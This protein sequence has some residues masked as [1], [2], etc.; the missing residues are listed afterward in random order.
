MLLSSMVYIKLNKEILWV[1]CLIKNEQ[2]KQD[3]NSHDNFLFFFQAAHSDIESHGQLIK[4]VVELCDKYSRKT[5][6]QRNHPSNNSS[7][8]KHSIRHQPRVR[9]FI[10]NWFYI[11]NVRLSYGIVI[12][13]IT[14]DP[15]F[16]TASWEPSYT[17]VRGL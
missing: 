1:F 10:F 15:F 3:V 6:K 2:D 9:N 5:Y 4:T 7:R 8:Q 16:S 17:I 12:F 14:Y 13:L 11:V